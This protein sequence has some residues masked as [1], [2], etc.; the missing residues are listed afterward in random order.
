MKTT[1]TILI[2]ATIFTAIFIGQV[3][4]ASW[5]APTADPTANNTEAPINVSGITQSKAGALGSGIFKAYGDV[6]GLIDNMQIVASGNSNTNKGITIG[7]DTS[8]NVGHI[9]SREV[10]AGSRPLSLNG[11]SLYSTGLNGSVGIGNNSPTQKLD[12]TGNVKATQFCLGA[13]CISDWTST[14]N[15]QWTN[16]TG[17]INYSGGNVGVGAST[18]GAKFHVSGTSL[19]DGNITLDIAG[20]GNDSPSLTFVRSPNANWSFQDRSGN[21]YLDTNSEADQTFFVSNTNSSRVASLDVEGNVKGSQLCIGGDC[22]T[23]W[24]STGT[25]YVGSANIGISG[26]TISLVSSPTVSSLTSQ[27]AISANSLNQST[28]GLLVPNGNVGI[29]TAAPSS[30]LEVVG[31]IIANSPIASNHVATKGYVDAQAGGA[32]SVM[33]KSQSSSVSCPSG[34]VIAKCGFGSGNNAQVQ[35]E[36]NNGAAQSFQDGIETGSTLTRTYCRYN[37]LGSQTAT[38]PYPNQKN[39]AVA[40]C[41]KQ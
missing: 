11:N 27:G 2:S 19:F 22:R 3:V 35:S 5:T 23:A 7:Y 34:Y 18:P 6:V 9:Y 26:S 25:S 32:Q 24:P 40:L 1:K 29:G 13:S 41:V 31:N 30:K 39:A 17:G 33:V 16:V 38:N 14:G 12:V 37:D 20:S 21:F 10:G 28:Y 8:G 36:V 4:F 15:S